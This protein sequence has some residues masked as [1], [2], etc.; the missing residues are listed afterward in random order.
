MATVMM[1][2]VLVKYGMYLQRLESL[3]TDITEVKHFP[4]VV[5]AFVFDQFLVAVKL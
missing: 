2:H 5:C 1:T 4:L 3:V